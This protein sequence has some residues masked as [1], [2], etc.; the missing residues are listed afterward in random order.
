MRLVFVENSSESSEKGRSPGVWKL[1]W[2]RLRVPCGVQ[3]NANN[4]RC[5]KEVDIVDIVVGAFSF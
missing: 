2:G 1:K 4:S 5:R 3:F